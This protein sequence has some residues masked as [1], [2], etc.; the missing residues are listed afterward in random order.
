[1]AL[2][3]VVPVHTLVGILLLLLLVV[4]TSVL[5]S[6][7]VFLYYLEPPV[8]SS[9]GA[10]AISLISHIM[11]LIHLY[12]VARPLYLDM[13]QLFSLTLLYYNTLVL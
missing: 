2:F 7:S 6:V 4:P 8:H 5:V 3:V 1:M 13:P 12:P 11:S 9:Y 10:L